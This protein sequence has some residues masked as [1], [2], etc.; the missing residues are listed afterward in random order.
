MH[1]NALFSGKIY[2][3]GKNFTQQLVVTVATNL[4][5]VPGG[6][7]VGLNGYQ[8]V[9]GVQVVRGVKVVQVVQV[10]RVALVVRVVLVIKFVNAYGL[11][12]LNNQIMEKT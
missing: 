8:F 4:N 12:G 11:P 5:S 2:T 1:E 7:G 6:Q 9:Q 3:D 10:V